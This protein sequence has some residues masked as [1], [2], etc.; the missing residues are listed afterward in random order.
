MIFFVTGAAASGKSQLAETIA[1]SL[2]GKLI[3]IAT[4][5]ITSEE[6]KE[7]VERH[8]RLRE[9]KG[10]KTLERPNLLNPLPED[11]TV[12]LECVSTFAA[13]RMFAQEHP[14]N[15]AQEIFDEIMTLSE[16]NNNLVIVSA[17]V[18]SD[19]VLHDEYTENYKKVM[20]ALNIMLAD[21]A[22]IALESV[23]GIPN[24]LKGSLSCL[25]A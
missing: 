4:M 2:G 1:T 7:K 10:F 15:K 18:T 8:I 5:P 11:S 23:Y 22:D 16:H 3:Y 12:L 9:G 21:A 19:G 14:Q 20:S 25:K 24:I 17:E 6:S 13:N